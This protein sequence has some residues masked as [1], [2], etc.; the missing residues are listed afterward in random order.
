MYLQA[1]WIL[2]IHFR[3]IL[4][5]SVK[6]KTYRKGYENSFDPRMLPQNHFRYI[7]NGFKQE[8]LTNNINPSYVPME[9]QNYFARCMFSLTGSKL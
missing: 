9:E 1:I 8:T 4:N 2:A 5:V 6:I 3:L 7:E